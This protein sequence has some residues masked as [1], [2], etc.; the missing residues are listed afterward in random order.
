MVSFYRQIISSIFQIILKKYLNFALCCVRTVPYGVSLCTF[1][2]SPMFWV[3]N[4]VNWAISSRHN[5]I[6][7]ANVVI[8][9]VAKMPSQEVDGRGFLARS[10][11]W[12]SPKSR[13]APSRAHEEAITTNV[14]H[15]VTWSQMKASLLL[16]S[17]SPR[18]SQVLYCV[19]NQR[20]NFC[21]IINLHLNWFIRATNF[22]SKE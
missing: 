18:P 21:S 19:S 1:L 7:P 8:A 14:S 6:P 20:Q 5:T 15:R 2:M 16:R 22:S 17:Q 13:L 4:W 10:P 11:Q 9:T 3:Y 12:C